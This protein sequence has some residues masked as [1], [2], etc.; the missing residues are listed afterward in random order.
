[1]SDEK[2]ERNDIAD[3]HTKE[4]CAS[5]LVDQVKIV[6]N[7]LDGELITDRLERLL[8]EFGAL[9]PTYRAWYAMQSKP[10][11]LLAT[12]GNS[13]SFFNGLE[14]ILDYFEIRKSYGGLPIPMPCEF[15][16]SVYFALLETQLS[17]PIQY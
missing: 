14:T 4:V 1:M 16:R 5:M 10:V 9:V 8:G 15:T 12:A 7:I 3:A 11:H 17:A 6:R 13:T 2:K